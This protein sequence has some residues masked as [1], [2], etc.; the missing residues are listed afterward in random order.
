[1][2]ICSGCRIQMGFY[3][4]GKGRVK[5]QVNLDSGV[6]MGSFTEVTIPEK[7]QISETVSKV[8]TGR[9]A[10]RWASWVPRKRPELGYKLAARHW[11]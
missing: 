1:M 3:V 10:V 8:P 5:L 9:V 4:R 2:K 11:I 7:K 6:K